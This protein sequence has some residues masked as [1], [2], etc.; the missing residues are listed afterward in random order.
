MKGLLI[1]AGGK[2]TRLKNKPF[3]KFNGIP[4]LKV[5]YA[6]LSGLFDEVAISARN[7]ELENEIKRLT[8]NSRIIYDKGE[9]NS[10]RSPLV[11][12]VSSFMEM[13]SRIVFVVSC[14]VPLVKKEVTEI[15]LSGINDFDAAVP[16][17][18]NG[19]VEP[20]I[21]AYDRKAML[22]AA[23][24]ALD[25]DKLSV[26]DALKELNVNYITVEK[27]KKVDPLLLSFRNVNSREDLDDLMK[28]KLKF[29]NEN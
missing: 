20:L 26:R 11:G 17:D 7:R 23:K 14:D 15:I 21:A 2:A 8:N 29:L 12:I 13:K 5:I 6:E 28:L 24:S 18:E 16:E 22:A 27:F 25:S 4:M 1:L 9:F 10:I 19:F 3:V